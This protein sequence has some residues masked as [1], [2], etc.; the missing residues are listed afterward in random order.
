MHHAFKDIAHEV[1]EFPSRAIFF[2]HDGEAYLFDTGYSKRVFENGWKSW[3]YNKLNPVKFEESQSLSEQLKHDGID[4]AEIKGIFISHLHPDHIGGLRDFPESKVILSKGSWETYKRAKLF[5]L[6]FYNLFP[7]N[8][9]RLVE[10][11]DFETNK[12]YFLDGSMTLL[13]LTGHTKGQM[14][15]LFSEYQLLFGADF[16][17]GMDVIDHQLRFPARF[18]QKDFVAYQMTVEKVKDWQTKG[19][20]VVVSHDKRDD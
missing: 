6:V 16:C 11:I 13:D 15:L 7:E 1:R 20:K 9:E 10:K 14:G 12:D 19:V 3:L 17:W 2:R 5:D 18:F 4:L 8:F